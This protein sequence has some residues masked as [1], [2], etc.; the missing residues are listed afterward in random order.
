MLGRL[1][2]RVSMRPW[3]LASA[4]LGIVVALAVATAPKPTCRRSAAETPPA[5]VVP[6]ISITW[7]P[8]PLPADPC[9]KDDH[10]WHARTVRQM[11]ESQLACARQP[12][13]PPRTAYI[14]LMA[15]RSLDVEHEREA[16]IDAELV[17]IAPRA[18]VVFMAREEYDN[19]AAAVLVAKSIGVQSTTIDAVERALDQR[20]AR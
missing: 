17:R 13:T 8:P 7:A 12:G 4:G 5:L 3:L 14:A 18:A 11:I 20:Q 9:N 2:T 19:A 1:F 15:A 6:T 10:V 16:E